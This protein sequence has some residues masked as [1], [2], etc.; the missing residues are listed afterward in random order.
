MKQQIK[1]QI[2]TSNSSSAE[3]VVAKY[4]DGSWACSCPAWKFHKGERVDCKHI[5][6]IKNQNQEETTI[7]ITGVIDFPKTPSTN[8][9]GPLFPAFT[10]EQLEMISILVE[11]EI[12]SDT[13]YLDDITKIDEKEFYEENIT[14]LKELQ[15]FIKVVLVG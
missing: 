14:K 10:K 3:Y 1:R 4:D 15:A 2:V 5:L 12:E 8:C 6:E 9:F 13:N 7:E 11:N